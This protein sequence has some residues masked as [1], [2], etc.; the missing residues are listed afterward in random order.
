MV[1]LMLDITLVV[2]LDSNQDLFEVTTLWRIFATTSRADR[3]FITTF[4]S[5]QG[6]ALP[7]PSFR[8]ADCIRQMMKHQNFVPFSADPEIKH[9]LQIR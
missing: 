4:L 8:N 7:P 9:R 6:P 3:C 5:L 2:D 1:F